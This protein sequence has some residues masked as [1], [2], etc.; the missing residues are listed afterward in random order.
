MELTAQKVFENLNNKIINKTSAIQQLYSLIE[1]SEYVKTRTEG[2]KVLGD[3][4]TSNE[5]FKLLESLLISDSS[6]DVRTTAADVLRQNFLEKPLLEPMKWVLYH[7][8]SPICLKAVY[9]ALIEIVNGFKSKKTDP[10]LNIFLIDEL[11][12]IED[13]EFKIQ[14]ETKLEKKDLALFSYDKLIEMLI[15]GFTLIFLKKRYWR[16]KLTIEN[17]VITELSLMFQELAEIPE[18]IKNLTSLKSLNLRY[19]QVKRVEPWIESLQSLEK[20]NLNCNFAFI[21]LPDSLGALRS[22]KN[23][24]LWN[25]LIEQIPTSIG[26]LKSLESLN[27]RINQIKFLPE[28]IGQL[29]MLKKLDLFDNKL[30]TIPESIGKLSSLE[31]LNLGGNE[32]KSLPESIGSLTALKYLD[33]QENELNS[34]PESIGELHSLEYMNLSRNSLSSIPDKL[35]RLISLKELNLTSNNGLTRTNFI[36][37]LEKRGTRVYF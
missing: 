9:N 33:L 10:N 32:L 26:N 20:L 31:T 7:D 1:N 5:S 23:L 27:L 37:E 25:N 21:R 28:T 14:F 15:N 22:L 29:S 6:E 19:N 11:Q 12:Q 3:I 8:E 16:V 30:I 36:S 24:S 2:I 4:D 17:C 35:N 13:K 18:Q 34:L